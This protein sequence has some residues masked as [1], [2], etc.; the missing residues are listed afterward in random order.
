MKIS[1]RVPIAEE[2]ER[3]FRNPGFGYYDRSRT[4]TLGPMPAYEDLLEAWLQAATRDNAKR[5][6]RAAHADQVMLS[7]FTDDCPHRNPE[8]DPKYDG[9]E[10]FQARVYSA[11]YNYDRNWRRREPDPYRLAFMEAAAELH[12]LVAEFEQAM[13]EWED[14]H[15]IVCDLSPQG[16]IC[17]TCA[18]AHYEW[19]DDGMEPASCRLHDD[20]VEAY[21]DFWYANGEGRG[22]A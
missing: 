19:D 4:S 15:G 17:R 12:P 21:G 22:G 2:F 14:H 16:T 7:L 10:F 20:V 6:S 11:R 9:V 1:V 5:W 18:E 3:H 13:I 8:G